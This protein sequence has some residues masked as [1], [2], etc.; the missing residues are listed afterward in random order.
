MPLVLNTSESVGI[1]TRHQRPGGGVEDPERG[2]PEQPNVGCALALGNGSLPRT[3]RLHEQCSVSR[4]RI[5]DQNRPTSTELPAQC[6]VVAIGQAGPGPRELPSDGRGQHRAG[7]EKVPEA[8][9]S[10]RW[11][12]FAQRMRAAP[13]DRQSY[14]RD[15]GRG[16]DRIVGATAT[17]SVLIAGAKSDRSC[18]AEGVR[19]SS[20]EP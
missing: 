14:V 13:A 3:D 9:Q 6:T 7:V 20:R 8:R 5:V 15:G 16:H 17:R 2:V 12:E 19:R 11:A 10:F 4:A 1:L 18:R